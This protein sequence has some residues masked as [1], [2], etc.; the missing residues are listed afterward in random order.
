MVPV[1]GGNE[2][3][4]GV[5]LMHSGASVAFQVQFHWYGVNGGFISSSTEAIGNWSTTWGRA[6][7]GW[8]AAPANAVLVQI[9]VGA[10]SGTGLANGQSLNLWRAL[11]ADR[12]WYPEG[13]PGAA[14]I[15]P[16][17]DVGADTESY[18]HPDYYEAPR[19]LYVSVFPRRA[20][21][22][23][24]SDFKLDGSSGPVE[25][26]WTVDEAATFDLIPIGY[27]TFD[28]IANSDPG[29]DPL[30]EDSF[31]DLQTDIDPLVSSATLTYNVGDGTLTLSAPG[32]APFSAAVRSHWFPVM[33]TE[34][35]SA[36]VNAEASVAGTQMRLRMRWY[37]SKDPADLI[38]N[39]DGSIAEDVSAL[40]EPPVGGVERFLLQGAKPPAGSAFG[41]LVI[42]TSNTV[43]HDTAFS[44]VIIEPST[45]PGP[46]FDG[47]VTEG[48]FGDFFFANGQPQWQTESVYYPSF[49]SFLQNPGGSAR[50]SA[51]IGELVPAGT[52]V[53][54]LTAAN[55]LFP[56]PF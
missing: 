29:D 22:A 5:N 51:I 43:A 20:N 31:T 7:T 13:V 6:V 3:K 2:Y 28:D 9:S 42:E 24:N 53:K 38:V 15:E 33:A 50:A 19:T 49:R 23:I 46:Y 26:A 1:T 52:V 14:S 8:V 56:L 48:D 40:Y 11:L 27:P 54:M 44:K 32:P 41:R 16:L 30:T 4:F 17:S 12:S 35:M 21:L 47:N 34:D 55:G 39:A 36:A 10:V 18:E 45:V 37:S 25:D